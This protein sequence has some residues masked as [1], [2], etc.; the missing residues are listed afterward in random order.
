M[1][2]PSDAEGVARVMH[3]VFD[4]ATGDPECVGFAVRPCLEGL[5]R[6]EGRP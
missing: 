2:A 6:L 4:A 3:D 1:C 5:E